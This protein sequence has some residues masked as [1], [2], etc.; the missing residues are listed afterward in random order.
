MTIR[1][2]PL[3]DLKLDGSIQPR[4]DISPAIVKKYAEDMQTN[5]FPPITI[6]DIGQKKMIIAD[7]SHRFLAAIE[8]NEET[9]K[10]DVIKGTKVEAFLFASTANRSHGLQLSTKDFKNIIEKFLNFKELEDWTDTKIAAHL[11]CS[12]SYVSRVRR[13]LSPETVSRPRTIEMKDGSKQKRKFKPKEPSKSKSSSKDKPKPDTP[14]KSKI[15][16]D[17]IK[18]GL[19]KIVPD[20]FQEVFEQR[21]KFGSV[22]EEI[23]SLINAVKDLYHLPSNAGKKANI[24]KIVKILNDARLLVKEG[25]PHSICHHCEGQ[26]CTFCKNTG[27]NTIEESKR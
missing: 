5:D 16:K 22:H 11:R 27:W 13:K 2:V 14:P 25:M 8:L 18:D 1:H 3:K 17:K 10:A 12:Q 15:K 9:I 6:F 23:G 24:Q 20:E 26:K 21:T 19:G 7:G 4:T